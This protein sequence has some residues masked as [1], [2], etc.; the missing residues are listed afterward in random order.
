MKTTSINYIE[1]FNLFISKDEL[2]PEITHPFKQEGLYFAT[3]AIGLI[4][5]P[6]DKIDL[7]FN[8]QAKPQAKRILPEQENMNVV[9]SIQELEEK[10]VPEMIDEVEYIAED[11]ECKDCDGH[12]AVEWEFSGNKK[13][14]YE[15]MDCPVCSGSGLESEQSE[16]LTGNKI[17]NPDKGY[18]FNDVGYRYCE[19]ERLIKAA[20]LCNAL[21][22]T[23]VAGTRNTASAFK[24]NEHITVLIMPYNI[25]D[26]EDKPSIVITI[27]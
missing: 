18:I 4:C 24:L 23:K 25:Y 2:R 3:V 13:T 5:M 21:T 22:V 10:L 16:R 9:I 17:P 14:Y 19:L 20:K 11:V 26:E 1:L 27:P 12:G 15:E 6:T 8:E 7:P